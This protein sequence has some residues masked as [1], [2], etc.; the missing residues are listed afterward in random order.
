M[1]SNFVFYTKFYWCYF[2]IKVFGGEL[3]KELIITSKRH[4]TGSEFNEDIS[5]LTKTAP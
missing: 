4:C 1:S 3:W 5:N 2:V